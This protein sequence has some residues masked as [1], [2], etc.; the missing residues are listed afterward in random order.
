[1]NEEGEIDVTVLKRERSDW[2]TLWCA[3]SEGEGEG[4]RI[5]NQLRWGVTGV[6]YT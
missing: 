2:Q 4:A 6:L 1:M 5:P 3:S